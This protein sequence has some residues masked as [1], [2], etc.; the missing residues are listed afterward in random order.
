MGHTIFFA[1]SRPLRCVR[2]VYSVC[3]HVDVG[4]AKTLRDLV[5]CSSKSRSHDIID[6]RKTK[7]GANRLRYTL[8]A[9]GHDRTQTCHSILM[10]LYLPTSSASSR[11]RRTL[12]TLLY[13][14]TDYCLSCSTGIT[15]MCLYFCWV[16]YIHNN[17]I[18]C[19]PQHVQAQ[20][21]INSN[22]VLHHTYSTHHIFR[23]IPSEGLVLSPGR[24]SKRQPKC[25]KMSQHIRGFPD[26]YRAFVL[27]DSVQC[28]I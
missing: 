22:F 7:V 8:S 21:P 6:T 18:S 15:N 3:M 1:L 20:K 19:M 27:I 5:S 17:F 2:R 12:S 11:W 24:M 9:N 28:D 23:Y 16:L 25:G 4:I 13:Y 14:D 26:G 10:E